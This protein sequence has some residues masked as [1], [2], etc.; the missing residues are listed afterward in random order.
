M[1]TDPYGLITESDRRYLEALRVL[2]R[3]RR[4]APSVREIAAYLGCSGPVVYR[5]L[6]K[7]AQNGE[8]EHAAGKF[9]IPR[10]QKHLAGRRARAATVSRAKA[11]IASR[12]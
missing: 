3:R 2:R 5:V 8:L 1:P 12:K 9:K 10:E 11:V 6:R 7:L 4:R